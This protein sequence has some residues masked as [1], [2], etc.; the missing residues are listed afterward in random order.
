MQILIVAWSIKPYFNLLQELYNYFSIPAT[1]WES[2]KKNDEK[3]AILIKLQSDE[4][5]NGEVSLSGYDNFRMNT[6]LKQNLRKG[7]LLTKLA[8]DLVP[9]RRN[10]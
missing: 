6:F 5:R 10:R 1:R 2:L 9:L 3:R 7:Q 8:K 4:E